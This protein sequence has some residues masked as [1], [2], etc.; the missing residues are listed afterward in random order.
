MS[1]VY[2]S[3]FTQS[4]I[5]AMSTTSMPVGYT[6]TNVT[7]NTLNYWNGTEWVDLSLTWNTSGVICCPAGSYIQ[8]A[9]RPLIAWTLAAS[10]ELVF[11]LD[12]D[13]Y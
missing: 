11:A 12:I 4:Q 8:I 1:N 5:D 13:G 6:I 9:M 3:R 10:Q 7:T 2:P